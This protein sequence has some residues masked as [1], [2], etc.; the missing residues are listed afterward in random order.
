MRP[1]GKASRNA[2]RRFSEEKPKLCTGH[3][4]KNAEMT[5]AEQES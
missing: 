2:L 4:M 5:R 1:T 3:K